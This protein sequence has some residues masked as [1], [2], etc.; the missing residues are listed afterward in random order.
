MS[1]LEKRKKR[2]K[3]KAKVGR[4]EKQQELSCKNLLPISLISSEHEA[5]FN[6]IPEYNLLDFEAVPRLKQYVIDTKGMNEPLRFVMDVAVLYALYEWWRLNGPDVIIPALKNIAIDVAIA[7]AFLEH[8]KDVIGQ[9]SQIYQ[10]I[11]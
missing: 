2:A 4:V 9:E 3:Q 6:S 5:F 1:N 7:P 8:F 11:K 10:M